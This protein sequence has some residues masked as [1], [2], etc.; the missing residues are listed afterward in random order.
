MTN[1]QIIDG[2]VTWARAT[3]SELQSDYNYIPAQKSE[4][5]PDVV[6]EIEREEVTARDPDFVRLDLQNVW[7][8]IFRCALSIMVDN[9]DPE[10]AALL[11]R[12][13]GEKLTLSLLDDAT[14]G[15]QVRFASPYFHLDYTQP[16]VQYEDGTV[17]REMTLRLSVA[18][19]VSVD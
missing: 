8:R 17:G 19:P 18:E 12:A 7:L 3:C 4:A 9:S 11:L 14:L 13:M 1:E 5:L 10:A 15:E 6:A 16:F 2:V